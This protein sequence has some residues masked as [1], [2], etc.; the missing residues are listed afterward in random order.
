MMKHLPSEL[1][2]D[3]AAGNTLARHRSAPDLSSYGFC[4]EHPAV[5]LEILDTA[6]QIYGLER[7]T[8]LLIKQFT[9][10]DRGSRETDSHL[11]D[12]TRLSILRGEK[13]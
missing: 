4:R 8:C 1:L 7:L 6:T 5:L 13:D 12:W 10:I 3:A 2:F 11:R 9:A